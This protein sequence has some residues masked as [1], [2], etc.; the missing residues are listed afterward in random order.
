VAVLHDVLLA[1]EAELARFA[2]FRLAA[3]PDEVVEGDHL[4]ADEAALDVAVDLAGRLERRRAAADRPGPA[5][6]LARSE[7]AHEVEEMVARTDEPVA[8]ARRE[9]DVTEE[10]LTVGRLEL[11]DLGF[12]ARG[13]HES[14][15]PFGGRTR[16]DVLGQLSRGLAFG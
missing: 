7:E 5:L 13:E 10:S 16:G 11:R 4:G 1:L 2:A 14:L 8:R 15:G 6:V 12:Q 3:V 9:A